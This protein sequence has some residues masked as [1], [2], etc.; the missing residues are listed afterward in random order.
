MVRYTSQTWL[1][2]EINVIMHS[3]ALPQNLIEVAYPDRLDLW[4]NSNTSSLSISALPAFT[5]TCSAA[6]T[7]VMKYQHLELSK[8]LDI[9]P[10]LFNCNVIIVHYNVLS[11]KL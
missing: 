9:C 1:T 2:G 8:I 6:F 11:M 7:A 4:V 3:S 10:V 5:I